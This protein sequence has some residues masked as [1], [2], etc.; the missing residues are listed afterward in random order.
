MSHF[1]VSYLLLDTKQF[2][3]YLSFYES[4]NN[5][6]NKQQIPKIVLT[7]SGRMRFDFVKG[8]KAVINERKWSTLTK[9]TKQPLE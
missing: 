2:H 1:L 9:S 5:G 8:G 4:N 3:I 6:K 7:L